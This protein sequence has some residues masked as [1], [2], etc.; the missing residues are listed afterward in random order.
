MVDTRIH[1]ETGKTLTRDV[2]KRT[3]TYGSFIE[4]VE[5]PGWYPEDDSDSIHSGSDIS[6]WDII[7]KQL[8]EK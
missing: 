4:E 3:L 6:E 2:R 1:P 5:M 7:L 8:K